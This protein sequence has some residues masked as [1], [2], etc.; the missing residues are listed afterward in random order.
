M[1]NKKEQTRKEIKI[2]RMMI[3]SSQ[4]SSEITGEEAKKM[5]D[6]ISQ[7]LG[8]AGIK[9][10]VVMDIASCDIVA[11]VKYLLLD[12]EALGRENLSLGEILENIDS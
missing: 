2:N 3:K 6:E 10:D 7:L 11:R 9:S 8:D 12:W 1:K 4:C 5:L